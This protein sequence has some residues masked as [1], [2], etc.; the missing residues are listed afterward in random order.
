[1]PRVSVLMPTYNTR[2]EYL[3]EAV[4]SVLAQTFKDFELIILDDAS[5]E[6]NVEEVIRSYS[7]PRIRFEQNERNLGISESRN[8]LMD[9]ARGEYLA[10]LDHDDVSLP[11]RL[12]RQVEYLD[13]HPEVGVLGTAFV[14]IPKNRMAKSYPLEN[15]QIVA[16]LMLTGMAVSHSSSM[17]RKSVIDAYDI[18]YQAIYSPAED[19]ALCCSCIGKTRF[20]NLPEVLFH[21]RSYDTNT[22]ALKQKEMHDAAVQIRYITRRGN[23]SLWFAVQADATTLIRHKL[24]GIPFLVTKKHNNLTEH[25]L[26][27]KIPVLRSRSKTFV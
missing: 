21:Y 4:D 5:T 3:R 19:Y 22:S 1:M 25:L 18:K 15:D 16:H 23:P 26:F 20:A 24:F 27:G 8:K 7:D 9:M 12:A 11:E 17:L 6:C 2:P 14:H 10:V 13:A